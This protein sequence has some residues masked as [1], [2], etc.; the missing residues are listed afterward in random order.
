[1]KK[2]AFVLSLAMIF[3]AAVNAQQQRG[4]TQMKDTTQIKGSKSSQKKSGSNY[5]IKSGTKRGTAKSTNKAGSMQQMEDTSKIKSK[6]TP[7]YKR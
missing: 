6:G 5:Q 2:L 4:S 7:V 3:G 1:M